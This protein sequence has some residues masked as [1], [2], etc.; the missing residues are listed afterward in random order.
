MDREYVGIDL[1]LR[2]SV[3]VRKSADGEVLGTAWIDNTALAFAGEIAEAGERRRS[4]SREPTA[5]W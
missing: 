4:R 2:R 1:H 5:T 3:V